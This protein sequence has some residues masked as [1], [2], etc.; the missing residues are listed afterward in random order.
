MI[1]DF[2]DSMCLFIERIIKANKIK[3][4]PFK[5]QYKEVPIIGF[6]SANFD[7][8]FLVK[9]LNQN[10]YSI[11]SILDKSNFYKCL[12]VNTTI[13]YQK[14][15]D[16]VVQLKFG[17]AIIFAS[18]N[19]LDQFTQYYCEKADTSRIKGF[20]P[21]ELLTSNNYKDELSKSTPFEIKDFYSSLTK[22][23]ISEND[24]QNV[25]L[26]DCKKDKTRKDY[27]L[28]DN[29]L[30]TT[31]MVAPLNF[32]INAFIQYDIDMSKSVSVANVAVQDKY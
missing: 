10:K 1:N 28:H 26:A 9:Y 21:Y 16:I 7:M 5:Y 4:I 22:S 15:Q 13:V 31:I 29:E 25:Y 8:N 32:L 3:G 12:K 14:K 6:N 27:L 11:K 24:Y 2:L 19:N 23:D 30:D 17:D 20:F 18:G